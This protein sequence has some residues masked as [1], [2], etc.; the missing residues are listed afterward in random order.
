ML[1]QATNCPIC[2]S[3]MGTPYLTSCD[4]LIS[5]EIFALSTCRQCGA[6]YTNPRV[7]ETSI[8]IYYTS[9]YTS[10]AALS[11]GR[12]KRFI[13]KVSGLF[14]QSQHARLAALLKKRNV[15]SL[16]EVGP[17]N[18]NLITYL[19]ANG[20]DVKGVEID[21]ACVR[22]IR[23]LGITCHQGT[24]ETLKPQQ[25][26]FDAVIMCQVL[27]HLYRPSH[28]LKILHSTL[29]DKGVL[30][31]TVPNIASVEAR[32]FGKYWRG[33]DLPRH[34]THF[35]PQSLTRLLRDT[36]FLIESASTITFPSSFI[37][38]LG[39]LMTKQRRFPTALYYLLYYLWKLASP[40][41]NRLMGSGIIEVVARKVNT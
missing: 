10:Y 40:L 31:L 15:R 33:L 3:S 20:F 27:E 6:V 21:D 37:E 8:N 16:L 28:N 4:F 41:H 2:G 35:T 24:I 14:F 26:Q 19:A 36:G 1:L 38:S 11:D 22:R 23:E 30:Y 17:G 18:G 25:R 39:I 29:S 7:V 32:L 34:V 13:R 12:G 5:N 9:S